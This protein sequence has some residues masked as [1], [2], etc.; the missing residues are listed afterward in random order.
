[1]VFHE[2]RLVR[3]LWDA[4]P[5]NPG[6]ALLV[7]R[8]HVETWFDASPEERAE[9]SEA[10]VLAHRRILERFPADGFNVGLNAG[11]AA[12]QT[13]PHLHLH[14]IPR[15]HGDVPDP[16]GGVRHV[17]PKEG[18]Y[19]ALGKE[20]R[21]APSSSV[22]TRGE[23]DPLLPALKRDI[24][25]ANDVDIAV[26]FTMSSGVERILLHL[27]DV[28]ARGG[29]LRLL[30]GDYLDVTDPDALRRLM[31]LAQ[32]LPAERVQLRIFQS[33]GQV[34][35]HPKTYICRSSQHGVAYV[36]SSN[37]SR[38]ALEDGIEWNYRIVTSRDQAG[39]AEVTRAFEALWSHP[40][41]RALDAE[42]VDGYQARRRSVGPVKELDTAPEAPEPPP[43]PNEVQERALTALEQTREA[44]NRAGLVVLATGLGKTWLSAFDSDR[45]EFR[46]VL[47]VA[48]REEILSQALQ[49]FRRIRPQSHLGRYDG[50]E[51]MPD[52]EV[53]FA[54][55]QT[56]GKQAH[57]ERFAPDAFD[58]IVVDEFHHASARTYRRMLE[59]FTPKFLLGLT[60]TPERTDG[61]D[62][63]Q[64]CGE[65]LVFRCDLVEGVR[66]ELLC[67]FH[68]FGV[69]DLVDYRNIP[70]RNTRF[71]EEALTQAVATQ[72]RAENAFEQWKQRGG[73][74]TLA[75]CASQRHADFMAQYFEERGVRCAA[76]HSGATSAPR[77]SSIEQ[78][79][80]GELQVLF[81]VDMFNEGVD[82]PAVDT[83]MMLRPTESAIL[84]LQQLGR[85]LRRSE[86]K[87]R[88][89]VIDYIGNHRTFLLKPRTL[90]QLPAGNDREL[91]AALERVQQGEWEL[92]PGC[93]VTYELEAF[94][95]LSSLMRLPKDDDA[96]KAYYEDFRERH[97]ERPT[98]AEAYH[99]GY[100]PRSAR[101]VYGSWLGFVR[102]MGDLS[103]AQLAARESAGAFLEALESTPMTKSY[104]MLV[105]QAMLNLDAFPGHVELDALVQEVE[106][107]AQ[108]TAALRADLGAALESRS[109]LRSLLVKHPL[110]AWSGGKG[111][112]DSGYFA[113]TDGVFRF[114]PQVPQHVRGEFQELVRE[115]ADWRLAEYLSR[116]GAERTAQ[117][118]FVAKVIQSGGKSPIL[119]LP[120]RGS[121]S[122]I[123]EGWTP[124]AINGE[125]YDANFV[126]IA[127]NVVRK[128]DS[129]Q[130]ELPAILRTWFGPDAG[131]PG[132]SF[133]VA[134]EPTNTG[135]QLAPAKAA[136]PVTLER[137]RA[138]SREQIPPLFGLTFSEAIW[139]QGFIFTEEHLVLLVTLEKGQLGSE[140]Q[141]A[142]RFLSPDKFQWQSQNRT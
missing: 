123:P 142:D 103:P 80:S 66:R 84:F 19:L 89:V 3:G 87:E 132:T 11:A 41:T 115:L 79:G 129:E 56:L 4:F 107:L 46:R 135:Y 133:L 76:V 16:R 113:S 98:A 21:P 8:R 45:P 9:L 102:A 47:F 43:P 55:I 82:V 78:L 63:L 1:L 14:V 71:D 118:G 22:L 29:T 106:R 13:V 33:G 88:L 74:R 72:A 68:Y 23:A 130:N 54:S 101:K 136:A 51:K 39:F 49:T 35:F 61:G 122:G 108:R 94:D 59:H 40:A 18:N 27:R 48:H 97:G 131:R 112:G 92:P 50:S 125:R 126:K 85:G 25:A 120:D 15:Q 81:A 137:W 12:G 70:W 95:L 20:C 37:L 65:N 86:G 104:K 53:L 128:P 99:D 134:C 117:G 139:N 75:F 44:G 93:E 96:L 42:W 69:P 38:T 77:A 109:A 110:D 105:L 28:V 58:Y 100:A 83:V 60:A 119:M 62:L 116:E 73:A 90:L 52:A 10:T 17:I 26:A 114:L 31:D 111:T 124:V 7:T 30:T 91:S 34:S 138:Y 6:H 32:E 5:V 121:Q 57:L 140:F 2:G 127:L 141:Y 36:G 24:D 64:L 67:P